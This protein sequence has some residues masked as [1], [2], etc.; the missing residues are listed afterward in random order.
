MHV[1]RIAMLWSSKIKIYNKKELSHSLSRVKFTHVKHQKNT[2]RNRRSSYHVDQHGGCSSFASLAHVT[3]SLFYPTIL[4]CSTSAEADA[5]L[6]HYINV[7]SQQHSILICHSSVKST[8]IT[9]HA[10][11][12]TDHHTIHTVYY[13]YISTYIDIPLYVLTY[14]KKRYSILTYTYWIFG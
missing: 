6:D 14:N 12:L 4:Q 10:V 11:C 9:W 13:I 8:T 5:Y 7:L 2:H 3:F 1:Q